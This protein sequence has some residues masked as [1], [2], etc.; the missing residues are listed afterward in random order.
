MVWSILMSN[1]ILLQVRAGTAVSDRTA[2]DNLTISRVD[3]SSIQR[4]VFHQQNGLQGVFAV[5]DNGE[6]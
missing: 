3:N 1:E 6:F 5:C 2:I 4:L